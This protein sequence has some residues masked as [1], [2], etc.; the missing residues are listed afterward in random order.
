MII[1]HLTIPDIRWVCRA[2]SPALLMRTSSLP[3]LRYW[4]GRPVYRTCVIDEDVQFAVPALL[5]RTSSLLTC[6][7]DEDVQ[8][9]VPALLMRTY[10]LPYLRYWWGRPVYRTC[11]IDEDVQFAV[12][13]FE[14]LAELHDVAWPRHIQV[15]EMNFLSEKYSNIIHNSKFI[16]LKYLIFDEVSNTVLQ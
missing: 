7:I 11:V 14:I 3:Y 6:V 13:A 1:F 5:M 4:W 10:S 12:V 9:T 15:M 2:H 8:F 16:K